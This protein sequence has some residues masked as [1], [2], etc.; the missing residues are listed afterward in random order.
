[1][2]EIVIS[3]N[4]AGQRLNKLVMKY[5]NKAPS[6]FVYRMIRK[7]NIKLNGGKAVGNEIVYVGDVVQLYLS[8]ETIASFRDTELSGYSA[9]DKSDVN[10]QKKFKPE[11]IYHDHNILIVNKPA[12]VLSQKASKDDYSLNES[13]IDYLLDNGYITSSQLRTYKPSICNRLDRNT[14][15]LVLCGVSLMGSQ[16]LSRIIRE[17]HI[18]KY[19]YTIVKGHMKDVEDVTA[20]L[21]KD[22]RKN[23]VTVCDSAEEIKRLTGSSDFEKIHTVFTPLRTTSRT[24]PGTNSKYTEVKVEL[25]TGKTHQIRAQL[26]HMGHPVIGDQKYGDRETNIYFRQNYK[27]R[28]QLL[29]CG[30]V[31]FTNVTGGLDY[32]TGKVFSAF[33]PDMYKNIEKDLFE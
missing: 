3:K 2:K 19:Y 18:D 28:N 14:S 24:V 10:T 31:E 5:L 32:L 27:L 12:G 15:G 33:K 17:R 16:E 20:Y 25:I 13:V 22:E 6:S 8:D 7:K 29:H 23:T 21:V 4:E 9:G 26:Q 11:I 30:E 1:M